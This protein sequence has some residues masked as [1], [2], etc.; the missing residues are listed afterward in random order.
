M[1][2]PTQEQVARAIEML[3]EAHVQGV[4]LGRLTSTAALRADNERLREA[5]EEMVEHF[6]PPVG[7]WNPVLEAQGR[8]FELAR[9]ALATQPAE[10]KEQSDGR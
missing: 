7:A 3:N 9:Q 10:H 4:A 5:L 6:A 2:E 1:T 8:A